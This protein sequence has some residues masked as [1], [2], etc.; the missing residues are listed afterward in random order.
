MVMSAVDI[1]RRIIRMMAEMR[2]QGRRKRRR[3]KK[4]YEEMGHNHN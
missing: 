1:E 4:R 2:V 3:P